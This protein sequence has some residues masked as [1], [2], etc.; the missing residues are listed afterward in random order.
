MKLLNGR[1]ASSS[2]VDFRLWRRSLLSRLSGL[3][4]KEGGELCTDLNE[5]KQLKD[6][7]VKFTRMV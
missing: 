5:V 4:I 3:H 6:E 1:Q 2:R 7:K